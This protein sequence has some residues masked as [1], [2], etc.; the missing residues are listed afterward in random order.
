M[1]SDVKKKMTLVGH[2][3]HTPK[4]LNGPQ[5]EIPPRETCSASVSEE[6]L[7]PKLDGKTSPI[8]VWR[9][10]ILLRKPQPGRN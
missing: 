2:P 5:E 6:I 10:R 4:S 9:K 7:L 8:N 1:K 3:T